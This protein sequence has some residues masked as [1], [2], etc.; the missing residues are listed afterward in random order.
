LSPSSLLIYALVFSVGIAGVLV[1][2][3]EGVVEAVGVAVIVWVAMFGI[4]L[5]S[6][7]LWRQISKWRS[8]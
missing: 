2:N 5:G 7:W 4:I 6:V 3:G 1:L 8:G